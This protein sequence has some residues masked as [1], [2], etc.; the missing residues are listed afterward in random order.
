LTWVQ[1]TVNKKHQ[2]VARTILILLAIPVYAILIDIYILPKTEIQDNI[3]SY[4][5]ITR[6]NSSKFGRSTTVIGYD[7]QTEKNL[8]FST[9][10][11]YIKENHVKLK[12]TKIFN[13]I[14]SASTGEKNYSKYLISDFNTTNLYFLVVLAISIM[15]SLLTLL[16]NKNISENGFKN[17]I[18]FNSIM[19]LF[20]FYTLFITS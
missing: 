16:R 4:R 19:L 10:E 17:I 14:K 8:E 5:E 11:K 1:I 15:A 2:F 12:Q 9:E 18:L 7:Y 20:I 3:I 13:F 6:T